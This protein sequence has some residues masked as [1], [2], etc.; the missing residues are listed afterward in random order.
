MTVV[1]QQYRKLNPAGSLPREISEVVNN[2]VEGKSNNVGTVTLN[3]GWATTTTIFNERIGFSSIILIAPATDSAETDT[4]PYGCFT[5]NTD[6]TAPSV[7]STAVVIYD[8]TEEANGIYRDTVNTSRIYVRNAGIYNIQFSVQLVN[9]DNA[10]Q[11][12]DIWFR[13]NGTDVPRS[14]SRFDIPA[15]KSATV[16]GHTIGTVNTFIEMSAGQYVE[17]AGT[18]SS[19]LIGLE[20]YPADGAIPSPAIPSV[21]LTVQYI[22]PFSADNVYISATGKG[23]ATV[24]H[25]ANDTAGKTY[26]YLVVG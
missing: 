19:T 20:S 5:N 10:A 16:W 3:T 6:Q 7:G 25:F 15:R 13:L 9:K 18:T 22:A 17:I 4:A 24:S 8:T 1:N 14:A 2:L 12:A 26:K 23:Q 21:I 11:Y